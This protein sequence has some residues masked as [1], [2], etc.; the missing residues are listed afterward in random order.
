[1]IKLEPSILAADFVHL[2]EEDPRIE[3]SLPHRA[4]DIV[5]MLS[6]KVRNLLC[7]SQTD[8]HG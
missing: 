8:T 4:L 6:N 7:I 2:G 1:M 3:S 5:T